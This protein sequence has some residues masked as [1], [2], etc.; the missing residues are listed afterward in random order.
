MGTLT[1]PRHAALS[2][3]LRQSQLFAA[4]RDELHHASQLFAALVPSPRNASCFVC[5]VP[6]CKR[7]DRHA[8]LATHLLAEHFDVVRAAA[9]A[10]AKVEGE[11]CSQDACVLTP[12][13]FKPLKGGWASEDCACM[14]S[15][16]MQLRLWLFGA[17]L[18]RLRARS[19]AVPYLH[20][21]AGWKAHILEVH[22]HHVWA[23]A[24]KLLS[25]YGPNPS[26][27]ASSSSS[28]KAVHQHQHPT[29]SHLPA[30]ASALHT[31]RRAAD[32]ASDTLHRSLTL[33]ATP[34]YSSAAGD[35]ALHRMLKL[36]C[37]HGWVWQ[38]GVGW[39]RDD[40]QHYP[41]VD[42]AAGVVRGA[43]CCPQSEHGATVSVGRHV[44]TH[45][46]KHIC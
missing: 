41:W 28:R 36:A 34:S 8:Q 6:G 11:C 26:A 42:E 37:P 22:L 19:P 45:L 40:S 24:M 12:A 44:K 9:A 1:T 25:S 27:A 32:Y 3:E 39:V 23:L 20:W 30:S 14:S 33:A 10:L 29:P 7:E 13:H 5:P 35:M 43:H 4:P 15:T 21:H 31:L 46:N 2:L 17:L 16:S 38:G 18:C